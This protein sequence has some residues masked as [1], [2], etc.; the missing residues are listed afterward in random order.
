MTDTAQGPKAVEE[1]AP[2]RKALRDRLL[3]KKHEPKSQLVT[4]FGEEVEIR[5]PSL[6]TML[7]T[8][9]DE[10]NQDAV[11]NMII[12]Y[13]YV[14]GTDEQLFEEAD[15]DTI[16]NWPFGEDLLEFQQAIAKLTGVDISAREGE[17]NTN[18]L[19]D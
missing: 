18:P 7:E 3:G 19:P 15:K 4:L 1:A 13:S 5:Q 8:R 11:L 10:N 14:P 12:R 16:R 9:A 2:N 6:S 17:L